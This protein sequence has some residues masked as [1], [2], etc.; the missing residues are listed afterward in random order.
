MGYQVVSP[1][2]RVL[3]VLSALAVVFLAS[4]GLAQSASQWKDDPPKSMIGQWAENGEC[5]SKFSDAI[6]FARGGYRWRRSDGSWGFARGKYNYD[7]ENS[8]RA[9]FKVTRATGDPSDNPYDMI[10]SVVGNVMTK[11]NHAAGT[12]KVYKSCLRPD[13]VKLF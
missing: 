2:R 6:Y 5:E 4:D 11:R 10:L 13:S 1:V 12:S 8:T 3:V 7:G 9:V